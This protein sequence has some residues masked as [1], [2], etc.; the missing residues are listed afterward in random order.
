MS[1]K[2]KAWAAL[3]ARDIMQTEVLTVATSTPISEVER[4]LGEHRIGGIPVTDEAGHIAGVLSMRDLLELYSQDEDSRPRRGPGFYHLSSREMLEEDF[5][6]FEV[7]DE[8]EE[9]AGQV[10]TA[11]VYSVEASAGL[12]K[13]AKA[14]AEHRIHRVLVQEDRKHVGLISTMDILQALAL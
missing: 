11:E 9:T 14:M 4:L 7:P 1:E 5:D 12:D 2:G 3:T 6:S 10:M 8:A 13:I